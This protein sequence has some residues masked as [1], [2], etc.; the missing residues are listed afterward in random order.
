[1]V[2]W[3]EA[4]LLLALQVFGHQSVSVLDGGFL[5]WEADGCPVAEEPPPNPITV[6]YRASLRKDLVMTINDVTD[7]LHTGNVQV[8]YLK[9]TPVFKTTSGMQYFLSLQVVDARSKG[10]YDGTDTEPRLS[11]PSGHMIGSL[12]LP[13]YRLFNPQSKTLASIQVIEE[14]KLTLLPV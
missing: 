8:C 13:F 9:A 10:R 6:S 2:C 7:A 11:L 12:N 3:F 1:M 14:G 5:R 4:S